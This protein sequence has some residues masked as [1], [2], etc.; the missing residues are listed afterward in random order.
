MNK[1][2]IE[3]IVFLVSATIMMMQC[4]I[5]TRNSRHEIRVDMQQCLIFYM[6]WRFMKRRKRDKN[7]E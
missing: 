4:K 3:S 6:N 2:D 5:T 7:N 1:K